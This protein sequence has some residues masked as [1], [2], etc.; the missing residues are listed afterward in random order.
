MA[1]T[2][3]DVVIT[4]SLR[5]FTQLVKLCDLLQKLR[6]SAEPLTMA[7]LDKKHAEFP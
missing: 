1:D 4:M 6:E 3:D 2:E 7:W 5:E